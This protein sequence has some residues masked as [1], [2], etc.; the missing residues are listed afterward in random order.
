MIQEHNDIADQQERITKNIQHFLENDDEMR[1]L[2]DLLFDEVGSDQMKL[3]IEEVGEMVD[4][5]S[6]LVH[7]GQTLQKHVIEKIFEESLFK[8]SK[9]RSRH[10]K[11]T[12]SCS[13]LGLR[14]NGR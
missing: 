11:E 12:V 8:S 13:A 14:I 1:N 4:E 7:G 10:H 6:R 5:L 2:V 9:V 3:S